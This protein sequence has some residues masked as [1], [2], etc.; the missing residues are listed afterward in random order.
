MATFSFE[1]VLAEI[2]RQ[3]PI[4]GIKPE[5]AKALAV[6]ENTDKPDAAFPSYVSGKTVSPAGAQGVMQVMPDTA[7]GLK[8]VGLLPPTWKY[9]PANLTTQVQAG[10]AAMADHRSRM[11]NPDDVLEFAAGYNGSPAVHKAYLRGDLTKLPTEM[12][13]YLQ[14]VR[15]AATKFGVPTMDAQMTPT[16]S[17]PA[18]GAPTGVTTTTRRSVSDP[19]ALQDYLSSAT[20]IIAPGGVIDKTIASVVGFGKQR[21]DAAAGVK[22]AIAEAGAAAGTEA[23]TK[24]A[25]EAAAATRRAGI[26]TAANLNPDMVGNE[27]VRTV[28][29]IYKTDDALAQMRPEI[30]A[31]MAVGFFDNPLEWLVNQTR[32]PGMV[33]QYNS[34]ART[35]NVA[36]DKFKTLQNIA[37]SQQSI[38]TSMDADLISQAAKASAAATA[39]KAAAE[40]KKVDYETVGADIRD[41]LTIAQ[42]EGNRAQVAASILSNTR[43]TK[44]IREGESAQEAARRQEQETVDAANRV[45]VA[46]G[47]N[48]IP[49]YAAY[50]TLSTRERDIIQSAVN[51]G[52]FGR[53]FAES[54]MFVKDK[55]NYETLARQGGAAV[56]NWTQATNVKAA[57]LVDFEAAKPE[58]RGKKLDKEKMMLEALNTVQSK[59]QQEAANDMR[60]AEDSNPMKL[61]YVTLAKLPELANNPMAIF[62]NTY[63]PQGKEPQFQ[64]IDEQYVLSRFAASVK[65]GTMKMPDAVAA[66]NE[67]YKVAT[68]KQAQLTAWP[69]FGLEKP[70]KMYA[71][72]LPEFGI[73]NTV[74]LGN[75]GQVEN[76]LTYK[77]ARDF[78]AQSAIMFGRGGSLQRAENDAAL[79]QQQ[80][81]TVNSTAMVP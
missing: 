53:D 11:K 15:A 7:E 35:Q 19:A 50:K 61:S 56:R 75:A 77:I 70:S 20:G 80:T 48:P 39:A 10:L 36:V 16:A 6:A 71:V 79:R 42:L 24:A 47:G 9:D 54:F 37:S 26:L 81:K 78:R 4:F 49:S 38:S 12:Q 68:A 57:Q 74:D 62:I 17:T 2:D 3:A 58:N 43:E 33:E 30:D 31:R 8:K 72:K 34:V 28:D 69:M 27:M 21:A 32:L 41:A 44:V 23:A 1:Q 14:K 29:T 52:K 76:L 45:I 64:K 73:P 40:L 55:G 59:Y 65:D 18:T 51:N 22:T 25:V 5:F 63:G 60:T 67:F 66:I 46:A 13:G